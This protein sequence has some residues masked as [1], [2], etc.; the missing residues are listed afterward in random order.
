MIGIA[1][2]TA[3]V[4]A[5]IVHRSGGRGEPVGH[6][7]PIDQYTDCV[8]ETYRSIGPATEWVICAAFLLITVASVV[9][10]SIKAKKLRVTLYNGV[11]ALY[12]FLIL[13]SPIPIPAAVTF[14][15]MGPV[16]VGAHLLQTR[17]EATNS[18]RSRYALGF[19]SVAMAF[20]L[21]FVLLAIFDETMVLADDH[22]K[23][24]WLGEAQRVPREG[25]R[26][27]AT[28]GP[29]GWY[30]LRDW[31]SW[32]SFASNDELGPHIAGS[33]LYWGPHGMIRGD[34]LGRRL[35]EWAGTEPRYRTY[36]R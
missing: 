4:S 33:D 3:L 23:Y 8:V 21:F 24:E 36:D 5:I 25:L 6:P 10:D 28:G 32:T 22:V 11:V 19:A 30:T 31:W 27:D 26:V 35:A 1:A 13:V 7:E 34:D 18:K 9:R 12:A 20:V 15:L 14:S 17:K 16:F 29:R 2:V